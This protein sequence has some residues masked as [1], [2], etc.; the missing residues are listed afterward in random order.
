MLIAVAEL[1]IDTMQ[2]AATG[3][4]DHTPSFSPDSIPNILGKIDLSQSVDKDP[5]NDR[6]RAAQVALN[7]LTFKADKKNLS[8]I[9]VFEGVDAAGKGG[10]IRRL[11][12]A[13]S[14]EHYEIVPR[15]AKPTPDELHRH[16]LWRF[17]NRIPAPGD[18]KIF[19]RSW[20]GRVL[21]ERVEGFCRTS[22]WQRAYEEINEFEA[23][24]IEHGIIVLKFWLH[25]DQDVQLER[26]QAREQTPFKRYKMTDEDYRNREK[27][28]RYEDAIN[29]M[30][31]RTS[32]DHAPWHLV[33][34]NDKYHAR[35]TVLETV[36]KALEKALD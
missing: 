28:P 1:L 34:A 12:S 35:L 24:L 25:I 15:I 16:Y 8:T 14:A 30:L 27:W 5:Y 4:A 21:V 18:M 2:R 36:Q 22:D 19:D 33:A 11:C 23:Q 20:Y 7:R 13:V 29:E 3:V 10:S 6:L 31:H 32:P 26:F 17:W 9:L